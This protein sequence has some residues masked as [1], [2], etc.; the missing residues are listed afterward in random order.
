MDLQQEYYLYE[1][2]NEILQ[3]VKELLMDGEDDGR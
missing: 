2:L 1:K 3:E